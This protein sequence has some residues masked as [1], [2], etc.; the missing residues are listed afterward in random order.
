MIDAGKVF[1]LVF[2]LLLFIAGIAMIGWMFSYQ[3]VLYNG[4][5]FNFANPAGLLVIV[6]I[7][8]VSGFYF[9]RISVELIMSY[10]RG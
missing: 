7:I 1:V 2:A 10:M 3:A 8:L 6:I 9:F 5:A 4:D